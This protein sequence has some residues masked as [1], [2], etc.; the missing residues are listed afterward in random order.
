MK[1]NV[2][3]EIDW[4]EGDGTIDDEVRSQIINGITHR[5]NRKSQEEIEKKVN[6]LISKETEVIIEN[7]LNQILDD[8]VSKEITVTDKWGDP[9]KTIVVNDLIKQKFD[10]F[11][12][13][14]VDERDGKTTD[15][16]KTIPRVEYIVG[17]RIQKYCDKKTK[18]MVSD[19][20]SKITEV[21]TSNMEIKI[22]N[23]IINQLGLEEMMSKAKQLKE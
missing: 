19:V 12:T 17:E 14:N 18:E 8:F 1:F 6:E 11:M 16:G 9:K 20:E 21:F 23:K 2:E 5:I 22:K 4:I 13:E 7:R 10:S 3:I 15:Y